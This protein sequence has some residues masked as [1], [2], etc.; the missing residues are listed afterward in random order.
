M[1][2]SEDGSSS[3]DEW[4]IHLH[5]TYIYL[6]NLDLCNL[7]CYVSMR[8]TEM[9]DLIGCLVNPF[10][11]QDAPLQCHVMFQWQRSFHPCPPCEFI[12]NI[13]FA[14]ASCS[15]PIQSVSTQADYLSSSVSSLYCFV[16][17]IMCF[18]YLY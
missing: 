4:L 7:L 12:F 14:I 3:E 11:V 16:L 10:S 15:F 8:G 2:C 6:Y 1:C 9:S 18:I 5:V 17:F 13:P